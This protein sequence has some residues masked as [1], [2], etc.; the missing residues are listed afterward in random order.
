MEEIVKVNTKNIIAHKKNESVVSFQKSDQ[1][2]GKEGEC[3]K[4]DSMNLTTTTKNTDIRQTIFCCG[5]PEAKYAAECI[6]HKK[7]ASQTSKTCL[8]CKRLMAPIALI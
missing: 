8:L 1:N 6:Q 5:I 4:R 2:D 3:K 7:E